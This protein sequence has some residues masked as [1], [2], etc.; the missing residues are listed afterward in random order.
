MIGPQ[1]AHLLIHS[2]VAMAK[3]GGQAL[4]QKLS[5]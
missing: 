5:D 2:G 1:A 4:S 3:L